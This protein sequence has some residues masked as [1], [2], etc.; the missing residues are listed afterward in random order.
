M[1]SIPFEDEIIKQYCLI[2]KE[3]VPKNGGEKYLQ[4]LSDVDQLVCLIVHFDGEVLNGGVRHWLECTGGYYAQETLQ[5]LERIG[6][7]ESAGLLREIVNMFP[8]G[9]PARDRFER[10]EQL[11]ALNEEQQKR[12]SALED[13]YGGCG[14]REKDG[15]IF[16]LTHEFLQRKR[17]S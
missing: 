13:R 10:C 6:A 16:K 12:I 4:Y 2:T 5:A 11:E 9:R 8:E 17:L 15:N 7:D 1:A 3:R 14:G